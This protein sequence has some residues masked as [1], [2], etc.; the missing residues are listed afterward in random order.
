MRGGDKHVTRGGGD[1]VLVPSARLECRRM[2]PVLES[3]A[4]Q[5]ALERQWIKSQSDADSRAGGR[6]SIDQ[7]PALYLRIASS[8]A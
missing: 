6:V 8:R 2:F 1:C 3:S 4:A 7:R 5:E